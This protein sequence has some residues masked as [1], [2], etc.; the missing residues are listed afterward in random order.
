MNGE[1]LSVTLHHHTLFSELIKRQE[2]GVWF[3]VEDLPGVRTG[4]FELKKNVM[5]YIENIVA[6][7]LYAPAVCNQSFLAWE[8]D[9]LTFE[10]FIRSSRYA[11]EIKYRYIIYCIEDGL[12][13]GNENY[14]QKIKSQCS[15]NEEQIFILTEKI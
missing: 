8:R 14:I 10:F 5:P 11:L 1:N 15:S 6:K 7:L 13:N 12:R 4:R 3:R 9:Y 2:F